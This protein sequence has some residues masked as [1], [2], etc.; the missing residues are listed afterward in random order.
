M[1]SSDSDLVGTYILVEL[2]FIINRS[3]DSFN[4]GGFIIINVAAFNFRM[5]ARIVQKISAAEFGSKYKSKKDAFNFLTVTA[6][7]YLP[8]YHTVTI[9]FLKGKFTQ[10]PVNFCTDIISGKKKHV[11]A[12]SIKYLYIP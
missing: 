11:K 10:S 5:D 7:A 3:V 2:F 9:Y 4:E 12:N 1:V 6:K 8:S